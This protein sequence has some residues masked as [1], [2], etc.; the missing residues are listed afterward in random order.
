M[1]QDAGTFINDCFYCV[2]SRGGGIVPR[3]FGETTHGTEV[4]SLA[5]RVY[6]LEPELKN[7]SRLR[8]HE[9]MQGIRYLGARAIMGKVHGSGKTRTENKPFR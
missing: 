7:C 6:I 4:R 9:A 2:D 3:H 8:K 1:E 5:F